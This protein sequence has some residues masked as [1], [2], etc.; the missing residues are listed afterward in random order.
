MK[1]RWELRNR[2]AAD[3]HLPTERALAQPSK[4]SSTAASRNSPSADDPPITDR[5]LASARYG[6]A[7]TAESE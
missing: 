6:S 2:P 3:T 4:R 7:T 1:T 5:I